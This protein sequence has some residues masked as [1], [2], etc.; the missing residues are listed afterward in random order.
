MNVICNDFCGCS[1]T[2]DILDC[3][4]LPGSSFCNFVFWVPYIFTLTHFKVL[5]Y[6]GKDNSRKKLTKIIEKE[7]KKAKNI[8]VF[9][10]LPFF[11][12]PQLIVSIKSS[13]TNKNL[14]VCSR[15]KWLNLTLV[16]WAKPHKSKQLHMYYRKSLFFLPKSCYFYH[17]RY[18]VANTC[19]MG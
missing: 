15:K 16:V 9:Q 13:T 14:F 7:R 18:V 3:P 1:I 2:W 8:S 6:S 12:F 11:K 17:S 4:Y 19:A 10:I 5:S